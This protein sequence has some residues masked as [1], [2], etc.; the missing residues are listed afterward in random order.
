MIDI[1]LEGQRQAQ[2]L[3]AIAPKQA[4]AAARAATSRAITHARSNISKTVRARYIVT[5]KRVKQ[6]LEITRPRGSNLVGTI[7]SK[8]HR[9]NIDAFKVSN[10]KRGPLKVKVLRHGSLK[11]VRGLFARPHGG[12]DKSKYLMRTT[13]KRYPLTVPIGLAVPQMVGSRH[14]IDSVAD[15]ANEYMA[16]RYLHE[17]EYRLGREMA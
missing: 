1:T 12:G 4:Q 13:A 7:S 17:I 6:S 3:L 8:G 11:A 14:V 2:V 5:A 9:L 16:K 15:D 10:N